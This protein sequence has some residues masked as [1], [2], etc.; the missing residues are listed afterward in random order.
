MKDNSLHQSFTK[1]FAQANAEVA[2]VVPDIAFRYYIYIYIYIYSGS[3]LTTILLK[4]QK[5]TTANVGDSRIIVCSVVGGVLR[6]KGVTRDH[7]PDCAD[8]AKRILSHNGRIEPFKGNKNIYNNNIY[9]Y[10]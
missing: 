8:E 2:K 3:T 4:G 5:Y 7:K 6:G 10:T 9:I 1:S